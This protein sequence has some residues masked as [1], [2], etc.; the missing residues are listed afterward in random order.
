MLTCWMLILRMSESLH[1]EIFEQPKVYLSF[2]RQLNFLCET[3]TFGRLRLHDIQC[4]LKV[5][6]AKENK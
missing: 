4:L 1:G 6:Q 2:R 3:N 5:S